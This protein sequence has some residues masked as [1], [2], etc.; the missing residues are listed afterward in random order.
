MRAEH[1]IVPA[2]LNLQ[3]PHR[4]AGNARLELR[5]V[6]TVVDGKKSAEFSA[7]EQKIRLTEVFADH[8]HGAA[9]GKV[10]GD[11]RPRAAE[12]GAAHDVRLEIVAAM[13]VERG[14]ERALVVRREL[15]A[16]H[17]CGVGYAGERRGFRPRLA[18]VLRDLNQAVVGADGQQ[19]GAARRLGHRR[20]VAELRSAFVQTEH[21]AQRDGT[22]HRQAVAIDTAGEIGADRGP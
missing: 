2:L 12:V 17:E 11:R 13:P 16:A 14:V 20:D 6:H 9:A 21:V 22:A 15:H 5:P 1:Q 10:S 8:L 18:V 4:H 7:D 3:V 19:A